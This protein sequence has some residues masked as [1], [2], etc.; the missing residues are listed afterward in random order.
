LDTAR[1]KMIAEAGIDHLKD[2]SALPVE[3]INTENFPGL[4]LVNRN[5]LRDLARHIRVGRK[6]L[7]TST[8]MDIWSQLGLAIVSPNHQNTGG[9]SGTSSELKPASNLIK[10]TSEKMDKF[11]GTQEAWPDWLK[12][13]VS[14][15]CSAGYRRILDNHQAALDDKK[16]NQQLY[17]LLEQAVLKGMAEHLVTQFKDSQDGNEAYTALLKWYERA[18]SRADLASRACTRLDALKLMPGG[19]HMITST[20]LLKLCWYPL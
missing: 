14:K 3:D 1:Q 11:S 8:M 7:W 19:T 9:L 10:F 5:Q 15:L 2:I 4:S 16:V 18:T 17:H 20:I 12:E 6:I 13:A